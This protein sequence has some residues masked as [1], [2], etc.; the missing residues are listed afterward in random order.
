MKYFISPLVPIE[1]QKLEISCQEYERYIKAK[2]QLIEAMLL[3]EKMECLLS[4]YRDYESC[5]LNAALTDMMNEEKSYH[6]FQRER[7]EI[8][9]MVVNLLAAAKA[10]LDHGGHH[11]RIIFEQT[12]VPGFFLSLKNNHYDESFAYRMMEALRDFTQHRGFPIHMVSF[13]RSWVGES[14]EMRNLEFT[15]TPR[16]RV[17]ELS[18]DPKFKRAVASELESKGE[19]IEVTPLVREYVERLSEI[20]GAVQ[21]ETQGQIDGAC[22]TVSEAFNRA[23]LEFGSDSLDPGIG[24]IQESAHENADIFEAPSL[25]PEFEQ[26]YRSL[27]NANKPLINLSKRYVSG[28]AQE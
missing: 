4:N 5:L 11:L 23:K 27:R 22:E 2:D 20:H 1:G 18:K 17:A 24:L 15:I 12:R 3:E 16:V 7:S 19:R 6:E 13:K 28:K 8:N 14:Q 26:R 21:T 25:T 10:Y 9:R